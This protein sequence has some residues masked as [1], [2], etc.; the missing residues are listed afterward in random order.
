MIFLLACGE[1][2]PLGST[3]EDCGTCH[4]DH[5]AAWE[6]SSHGTSG[7]SALFL[8]LRDE[9]ERSWGETSARA[10]DGCHAPG[11]GGDTTIG[12]VSCHAAIGDSG[13]HDGRLAVDLDA[14]L[15]GPIGDLSSPAHTSSARGYLVEPALCGTCHE[16]TGPRLFVEQT[17]TEHLAAETDPCVDCHAE[18]LPDGPWVEGGR[19]RP[20]HDHGFRAFSSDWE[21]GEGQAAML[22]EGL[23]LTVEGDEVVLANE[24][25]HAVPTGVA[26]LRSIRLDIEVGETIVDSVRLGADPV[27]EGVPVP[28]ITDADAMDI[29]TLEAGA[30]V[31]RALPPGATAV[32]RVRA[33]RSDVEAA[34]G[35]ELPLEEEEVARVA[36]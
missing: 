4:A 34:L 29:F 8:A 26:F 32:L 25:G 20:R 28:L 30:S 31:K 15:A 35:L 7:T 2:L 3:A 13:T 33:L 19:A 21:T 22:S 12:C 27:R 10:C 1:A 36:R 17:Y 6:T 23:S 24:A 9:A 18:A 5:Y 14:P 16:V 11:W